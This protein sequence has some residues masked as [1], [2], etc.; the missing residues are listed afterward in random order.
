VIILPL[1][2]MRCIAAVGRRD[3][4]FPI[5][6]GQGEA[7]PSATTFLRSRPSA[8]VAQLPKRAYQITADGTDAAFFNR[9]RR[10]A[11]KLGSLGHWDDSSFY[12]RTGPISNFAPDPSASIRRRIFWSAEADSLN[13]GAARPRPI[14]NDAATTPSGPAKTMR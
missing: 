14:T 3:D 7:A 13:G 2:A 11:A 1:D 8:D 12:G 10:D 9:V 6:C 4:S 5:Y